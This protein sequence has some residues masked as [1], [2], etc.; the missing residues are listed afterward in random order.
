MDNTH[1]DIGINMI[2]SS[3][4]GIRDNTHDD[5]GINMIVS[6]VSETTHMMALV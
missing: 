5:I 6:S 2:V 1:D 3:V 4:I